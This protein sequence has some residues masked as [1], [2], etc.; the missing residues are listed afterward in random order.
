MKI[1]RRKN[2]EENLVLH[3]F[4]SHPISVVKN[5]GKNGAP[6][7]QSHSTGCWMQFNND[8]EFSHLVANQK[9]K[10]CPVGWVSGERKGYY[11]KADILATKIDPNVEVTIKTLD[12]EMTYNSPTGGF[13]CFNTY[14]PENRQD[15]TDC[16]FVTTEK[17]NEL[18]NELKP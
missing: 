6:M 1:F 4:N 8:D 14:G 7:L 10:K 2:R 11:M 17:M 12:G 16:W 3:L 18:Y 13:M 5:W 15:E 9:G